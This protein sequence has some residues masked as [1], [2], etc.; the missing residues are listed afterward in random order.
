MSAFVQV[1]LV[2]DQ[3]TAEERDAVHMKGFP[4]PIRTFSVI[5]I[6]DQLPCEVMRPSTESSILNS[7]VEIEC[8]SGKEKEAEIIALEA[9]VLKLRE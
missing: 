3:V 4:E 5:N 2:N 7:S 1:S 9:M 8:L 6:H